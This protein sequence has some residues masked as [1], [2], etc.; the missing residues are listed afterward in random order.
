MQSFTFLEL[1]GEK[2]VRRSCGRLGDNAGNKCD[3]LENGGTYCTCDSSLCNSANNYGHNMLFGT[4]M[5]FAGM[6][7]A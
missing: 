7:F 1:N 6:K 3:S 5:A 4:V 2:I